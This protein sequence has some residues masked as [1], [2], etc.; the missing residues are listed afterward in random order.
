MEGRGQFAVC[1]R[2]AKRAPKHCMD[3]H[4]DGDPVNY[5]S[6]CMTSPGHRAVAESHARR[7]EKA[8]NEGDIMF[9]D[10]EPPGDEPQEQAPGSSGVRFSPR[11]QRLKK[12]AEEA[13]KRAREAIEAASNAEAESM[14]RKARAAKRAMEE[15]D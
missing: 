7:E 4:G 14:A 5:A 9:E 11:L 8:S 15:S 13:K 3:R 6:W 2:K 10:L 1:G 12:S